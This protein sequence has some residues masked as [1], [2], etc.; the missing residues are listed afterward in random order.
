VSPSPVPAPTP[1]PTAA[2]TL[3]AE[4]ALLQHAHSELSAGHAAQALVLLERHTAEFPHGKLEQTRE[5]ARMLALCQLG[6]AQEA[7]T[8][9]QH[10]LAQHPSSP[11]AGRVRQVCSDSP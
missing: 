8:R 4:F 3:D 10:F 6:R 1:Q 7:R 11:F 9:A 5:V 2:V